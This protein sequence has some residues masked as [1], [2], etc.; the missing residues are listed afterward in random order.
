MQ[1]A[2]READMHLPP[3][4]IHNQE[5]IIRF[6]GQ[7]PPEAIRLQQGAIRHLPGVLHLP[8]VTLPLPEVTLLLPEVILHPLEAAVVV[9]AVLPEVPAGADNALGV[10]VGSHL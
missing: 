6:V 8:E 2:V 1:V 4:T 7:R 5:V 3:E 10:Q 9:V